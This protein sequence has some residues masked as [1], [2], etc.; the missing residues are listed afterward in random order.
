MEFNVRIRE[1]K[2]DKINFVLQGVNL[3]SLRPS[4]LWPAVLTH[5]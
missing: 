2:Q 4:A 5:Q 1:L 3:G